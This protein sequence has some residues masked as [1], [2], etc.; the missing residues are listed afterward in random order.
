MSRYLPDDEDKLLKLIF[1]IAVLGPLI[2]Y[3]LFLIFDNISLAILIGN[4]VFGSFVWEL[5]IPNADRPN[6]NKPIKVSN[7]LDLSQAIVYINLYGIGFLYVF[8]CS[9]LIVIKKIFKL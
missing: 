2:G 4:M 9:I 6:L 5:E 3:I 7:I 1:V 8:V